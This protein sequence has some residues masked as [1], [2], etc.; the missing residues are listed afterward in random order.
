MFLTGSRVQV[1]SPFHPEETNGRGPPESKTCSVPEVTGLDIL[2]LSPDVSAVKEKHTFD[3]GVSYQGI[4]SLKVHKEGFG[5]TDGLTIHE[6]SDHSVFE[7]P[8]SVKTPHEIS[9]SN[10]NIIPIIGRDTTKFQMGKPDQIPDD[11]RKITA[12]DLITHKIV[13]ST[14]RA[15]SYFR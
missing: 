14:E 7:A 11:R 15:A 2:I 3:V 13:R 5:S 6:G 12:L 1:D 9:L 4:G 10:R 8:E